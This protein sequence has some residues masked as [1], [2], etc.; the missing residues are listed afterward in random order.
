MV[1]ES[2]NSWD[3]HDRMEYVETS[4]KKVQAAALNSIGAEGEAV[5]LFNPLNWERNDPVLVD[6]PDGKGLEG[7]VCQTTPEGKTMCSLRLP[8]VGVAGVRLES[9]NPETSKK[10][11]LPENIETRSTGKPGPW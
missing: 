2:E 4:N 1:Y 7:A 3:V 9:K 10:I 5:T 8:S 11:E 6:L